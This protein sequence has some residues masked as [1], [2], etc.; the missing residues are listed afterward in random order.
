M[1]DLHAC[2]SNGDLDGV[3]RELTQGVFVDDRDERND[4]A[5]AHAVSSPGEALGVIRLL[6]EAGADVHAT[7]GAPERFLLDLAA[8][9][10][11]VDRVHAL[12]DAGADIRRVSPKGYTV[13]V[14]AVYKL[15]DHQGLVPMVEFL[16]QNGADLDRETEYGESPLSVASYQGRFDVVRCLLDAGADPTRLGWTRLMQAVALGT[17]AEARVLLERE[18]GLHDRDAW[19]RTPW[20]LAAYVGD[21]EQGK[22]LHAAGARLEDRGRARKTALMVCAERGHEDM[23]RWLLTVGADLEAVDD[24]ANTALMRASSA[25]K[26]ACVRVLLDAGADPRRR[27]EHQENAMA[28][29]SSVEVVRLLEDAGEHLGDIRTGM[30]RVLTGLG[31]DALASDEAS[32]LSGQRPRFGTRNPDVMNVPFWKAMVRAGVSAWEAR[33]GFGDTECLDDGPVWCFQ[34]YG[35]SFTEL[36]DGSCVQIGGEH[37]DSYDPD[38]YIY[39]DVVVHDGPGSFRILGYPREVF[40]PTDF[41]S[42]TLVDGSIWIVGGLGYAGTRRYGTTPI[43]RL[44]CRTW[45]IEEVDARGPGPGWIHGHEARFVEP[46]VIRVSGGKICTEIDGEEILATNEERFVL[47]LSDRAW[48]RP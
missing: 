44:D 4:T 42:A 30:K 17:A 22:L 25:G 33:A 23:S 20:L 35:T 8:A 1:D 28:E 29:A 21:V 43:Y 40:P 36:P 5:L 46:D 41:H 10:G 15:H 32:F 26:A 24:S 31:D 37:E 39:N 14:H 34:R 3:R 47:R 7:V 11:D 2:A 38:F 45:R 48:L 18:G 12:L 13:L 9:T 19:G 16:V 27:N 6:I